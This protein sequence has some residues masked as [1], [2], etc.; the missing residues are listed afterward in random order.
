MDPATARSTP[1]RGQAVQQL[2][3]RAA[4]S[5]TASAV[6]RFN[7][8][9]VN[10]L[11]LFWHWGNGS[12][13]PSTAQAA[14]GCTCSEQWPLWAGTAPAGTGTDTGPA[15]VTELLPRQADTVTLPPKVPTGEGESAAIPSN[16]ATSS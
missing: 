9:G 13:E 1:S 4:A 11:R 3:D 12:E 7:R 5:T 6:G 10:Q 8:S 16:V 2:L 15:V 14:A